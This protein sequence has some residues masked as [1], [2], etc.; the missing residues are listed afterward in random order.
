MYAELPTAPVLTHTL[1]ILSCRSAPRDVPV[2]TKGHARGGGPAQITPTLT[3]PPALSPARSDCDVGTA[4]HSK[5]RVE[6]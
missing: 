3:A 1:L 6:D 2:R 5:G 4:V